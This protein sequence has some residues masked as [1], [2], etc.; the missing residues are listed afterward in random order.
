MQRKKAAISSKGPDLDSPMDPRFGRSPWFVLFSPDDA[1]VEAVSNEQSMEMAH[2][3]GIQ[4]AQMLADKGVTVVI[5]G[6]VGP[7]AQDTLEAAEIEILTVAERRTVAEEIERYRNRLA[8][9]ETGRRAN[10]SAST[11]QSE[12]ETEMRGAGGGRG[13][14]RGKGGGR[15]GGSGM[16]SGGGGGRGKGGGSGR[17]MGGGMGQGGRCICPHCRTTVDH[18]PGV[19]CTQVECP[20]CGT[21]MVREGM[22]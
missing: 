12:T 11:V 22:V 4:T 14:G 19:P 2:G 8:V 18:Q 1:S 3:A 6:R 10:D 7:K 21:L 16:G 5:T 17:G 15:G 13:G 20:K 9:V